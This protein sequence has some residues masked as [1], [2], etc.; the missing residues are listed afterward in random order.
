[1]NPLSPAGGARWVGQPGEYRVVLTVDGIEYSQTLM[2]EGDPSIPHDGISELDEFEEERQLEKALK[3]R[4]AIG[5][6]D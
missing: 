5:T 3:R 4:P 2:I 6:G 1:L